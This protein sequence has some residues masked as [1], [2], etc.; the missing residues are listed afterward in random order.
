MR[1]RNFLPDPDGI[2]LI[3]KPCEWTSHDIVAKVRNHFQLNKV[4][5]GGTLDPNATGLVVLLIG[6]GT[7]VSARVMGGDKTYEGEM[8][9]SSVQSNANVAIASEKFLFSVA[10]ESV[11]KQME[12]IQ[13]KNVVVHYREKKGTLPWRGDSPYIVDSVKVADVSGY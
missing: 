10:D 6:R 12:Q 5:H 9:L 4:G 3:D 7:R 13:G 2:L 8:I 11:A 1:K